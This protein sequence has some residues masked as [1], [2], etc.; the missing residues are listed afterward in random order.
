MILVTTRDRDI[1]LLSL[2]YFEFF[3]DLFSNINIVFKGRRTLTLKNRMIEFYSPLFLYA[4]S[5]WISFLS[6]VK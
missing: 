2:Y 1:R 6:S 3:S 5:A 4:Y